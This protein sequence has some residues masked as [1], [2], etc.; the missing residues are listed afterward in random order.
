[1]DVR[2]RR[3]GAEVVDDVVAH[4]VEH[5]DVLNLHAPADV[6]FENLL[7]YRSNVGALVGEPR[8]IHRFREAAL[9]DIRIELRDRIRVH[10]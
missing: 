7:D 4:M 3:G 2:K 1:M 6:L 9:E 8:V 10:G 5:G